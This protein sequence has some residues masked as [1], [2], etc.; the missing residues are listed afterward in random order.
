[1]NIVCDYIINNN[2]EIICEYFNQDD[3]E[4]NENDYRTIPEYVCSK[5]FENIPEICCIS[6]EFDKYDSFN[7]LFEFKEYNV[8]I[9][10][11]FDSRGNGYW[12]LSMK[13]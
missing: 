12:V 7:I 1:M 2:A 4:F 8:E 9:W 13:K 5:L 11:Y 10:E 6:Y 3:F